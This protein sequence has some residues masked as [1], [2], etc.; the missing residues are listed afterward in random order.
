[1]SPE[2]F[3]TDSFGP[4]TTK[5]DAWSYACLLIEMLTGS[6]P[7][8]GTAMSAICFKVVSSKETPQIPENLPPYISQLLAQCFAYNSQAR[9]NFKQIYL[10][11]K[12]WEAEPSAPE[13]ARGLRDQGPE[14]P[15][16]KEHKEEKAKWIVEREEL[17]AKVTSDGQTIVHLQD[18]VREQHAINEKLQDQ[19]LLLLEG[20]KQQ[21]QSNSIKR[22]GT[23]QGGEPGAREPGVRE[24]SEA[25]SS[26]QEAFRQCTK[27]KEVAKKMLRIESLRAGELGKEVSGLKTRLN[28]LTPALLTLIAEAKTAASDVQTLSSLAPLTPSG[29]PRGLG[30]EGLKGFA[31]EG[32]RGG[33]A[34]GPPLIQGLGAKH[35]SS[36]Q[37]LGSSAPQPYNSRE[38]GSYETESPLSSRASRSDESGTGT[39]SP[40]GGAQVPEGQ[41]PEV[42]KGLGLS[43]R[44]L[45]IKSERS[46]SQAPTPAL[47]AQNSWEVHGMEAEDLEL[48][49]WGV[50]V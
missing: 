41:G 28:S 24:L 37:G 18:R 40:L 7:W 39:F 3:D 20:V 10:A 25:L 13:G 8:A 26:A 32:R 43:L 6:R 38:S 4:V 21:Q 22:L 48:G 16:S 15:R 50:I 19:L 34:E 44:E 36:L 33:G 35:L 9:P 23:P 2:A 45:S 29:G 5:S 30:V 1:M 46:L 11:L 49:A 47:S 17:A 42:L 12:A 14:G 31:A 27:Q